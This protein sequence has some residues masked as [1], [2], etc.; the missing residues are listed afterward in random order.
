MPRLDIAKQ[1]LINQGLVK[2][3]LGTAREVVAMLG[4]VQAQDYAGAKWGIA[5]R[6]GGLSNA[7][8]DKEIDDGTIVRTHVL[9]PTWH[10]AAAADIGWMLE[11]TAPR[12]HAANAFWYRW[13]EVDDALARRSRAVMTKALRE[14]KHLTRSEL[15]E[16]LTR[17]KIQIADPIRLACIV[18]RAELDGLICNGARRG[19]QFTYALLEARVTKPTTFDRDGAL[20]ELARRYFTTRGPATLDDFAWW[21]GLTKADAKRGV[22]TAASHLRHESIDEKSYWAPDSEGGTRIKTPLTHLLPN[23]DE[24][25][26][27]LKD[28][29]AYGARLESSGVKPRTSALAGH[30]LVINGQIVGGWR[31]TLVGRS[32]LIEP[33]PLIRL[34][35]AEGRAVGVAARKFGRFLGLPPRIRWR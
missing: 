18:M 28:R 19:K 1:R 4:A 11:L 7:Q 14:G 8:I 32:V 35:E 17:A 6:T 3:A 26:V 21:S 20:S 13:L 24:Y 10:F 12:V 33:T 15:G 31:R 34:S 25:I 16:A 30:A 5:Q 22:E 23:Y 9:R 29:S 27:G 2:A